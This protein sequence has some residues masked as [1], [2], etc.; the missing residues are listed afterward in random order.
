M[1]VKTIFYSYSGIT[2][3]I[4]EKIQ[5]A[6]GG[7]LVEVKTVK[8]YSKISAYSMGCYRAMKGECD[9]IE[10]AS[11]DVSASDI[12]VIGT[13]VWAFRATPAINGAVE[14]LTGCGGK[15]AVLFAT[16]GG[17]AKDTLP[18]LAEA[19]A[20]KD[21]RIA[22]EYVFDKN[23]VQDRDKTDALI[24]AVKSAEGSDEEP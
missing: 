20:A 22:G 6:C 24:A 14:A 3:G 21:V 17:M 18:L 19:L 5:E 16:C 13:P 7:D 12:I 4:A 23:D 1:S 11:I 2:R 15:T 10:P 9:S 8:P